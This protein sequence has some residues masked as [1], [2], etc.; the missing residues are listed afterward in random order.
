M[1]LENTTQR[2]LQFSYYKTMGGSLTTRY[3]KLVP[4]TTEISDEE[5]NALKTP[6]GK[7]N[8]IVKK[9]LEKGDLKINKTLPAKKKEKTKDKFEEELLESHVELV[10]EK[11]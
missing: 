11:L 8:S 4:G 7:D 1:I 9:W 5:W 3:F 2:L 10:T 6:E